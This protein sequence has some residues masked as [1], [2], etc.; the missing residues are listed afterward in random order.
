MKNPIYIPKGPAAEY[1]DCALNIF[2]GCPH[3]C[4]YCFAPRVLRKTAEDFANYQ[5]RAGLFDAVKKQLSGKGF[6]GK[7]IHLCFTCDPF[8]M[9]RKDYSNILVLVYLIKESGANVQILTKGIVPEDLFALLNSNDKFGITLSGAH[10]MYIK[11][12]P[13]AAPPIKRIEQL[14]KAKAAGIQ[15]FVSCEPVLDEHF[16][17]LAIRE[18]DFIDEYRIGK[19]N[20]HPQIEA[21]LREKGYL[22]QSW[23]DFGREAEALCKERGRNYLIKES[24]RAEMEKN[25]G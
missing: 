15:T 2:T 16:I 8:P 10:E 6:A 7:L 11:Y 13:N 14:E 3:K 19:L 4:A 25:N 17:L 21:Y 23:D 1:A 5:P 20:Y 9:G 12:E 22:T 24:L 18:F